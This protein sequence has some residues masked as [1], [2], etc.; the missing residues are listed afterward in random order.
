MLGLPRENEKTMLDTIKFAKSLSLES[1]NF[2]MTTLYPNTGLW[3]EFD[4]GMNSWEQFKQ[5]DPYNMIFVP[6]GITKEVLE[7]YYRKAYK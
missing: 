3:E 5:N 6:K 2:S 7:K 1:A 4:M